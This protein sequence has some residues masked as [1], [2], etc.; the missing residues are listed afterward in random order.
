MNVAEIEYYEI[1]G[2]RLLGG[3]ETLWLAFIAVAYFL[4]QELVFL[5]PNVQ[6]V[7][8]AVWPASGIGLAALLLS[9][10]RRWPAIVPIL[11]LAGSFANVLAGKSL[12]AG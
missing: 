4:A 1:R 11:F 6:K 8:A 5:S 10:R 3:Q 7:V 12:A 2:P 9:P